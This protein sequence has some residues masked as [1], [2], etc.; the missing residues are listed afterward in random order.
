[1]RWACNRTTANWN[2]RYS[3]LAVTA[4]ELS[5]IVAF[6]LNRAY[7]QLI[8]FFRAAVLCWRCT[9]LF[10]L[11]DTLLNAVCLFWLRRIRTYHSYG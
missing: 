9:E 10:C 11:C 3:D 4:Q 8:E 5:G 2:V 1:M 7:G 6:F